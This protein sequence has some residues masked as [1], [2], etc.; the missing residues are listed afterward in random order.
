MSL[1]E[2]Q[3]K[4]CERLFKFLDKDKDEL[5]TGREVIIGLDVLGKTFT[6]SEQKKIKY[7]SQNCDLDNFMNLCAKY[8]SFSQVDDKLI[9]SFNIL[10]SKE[11]PGYISQRDLIFVLKRLV[12]NITDKDVNDIVQ[13]VG[14]SPDGYINL[15]QLAR[16][17]LLK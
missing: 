3:K 2:D 6:I 16:E 10:E 4:E 1:S 12:D 9:K 7:E 15:N 17:M 8:I 11:K 5:L 13:E 14:A